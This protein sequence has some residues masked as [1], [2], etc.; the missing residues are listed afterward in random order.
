MVDF[1]NLRSSS[2]EIYDDD[3]EVDFGDKRKIPEGEYI[4][5]CISHESVKVNFGVA[6]YKIKFSCKLITN[7]E[8]NGL[9][10]NIWRNIQGVTGVHGKK[11]ILTPLLKITGE[12]LNIKG[13]E[14]RLDKISA[15]WL[16]GKRLRV[17]VKTVTHDRNGDP[18]HPEQHYSVVYSIKGVHI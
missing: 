6:G 5:E 10:I 16:Y 4:V 7:D 1:E 12:L 3:I 18:R 2:G 9:L 17:Q 13:P 14:A 15:R 8:N 11:I